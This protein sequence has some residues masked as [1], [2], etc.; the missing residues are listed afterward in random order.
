MVA[1][2]TS[3]GAPVTPDELLASPLSSSWAFWVMSQQGKNA[4]EHWQANQMKTAE[5]ASVGDFWRLS[6]NIHLASKLNVADYSLFRRGIAPAWEDPACKNGGRW[7]AKITNRHDEAWLNVQLS[8][9]GE[10]YHELGPVVCGAVFSARRGGTKVAIWLSTCD[11]DKVLA[12]GNLF[13][14]ILADDDIPFVF[15]SFAHAGDSIK[16]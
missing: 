11:P 3:K 2:A 9:I 6:N 7:V 4:K 12:A 13:K 10:A 14:S 5:I 1:P 16:L 8:L 15:E